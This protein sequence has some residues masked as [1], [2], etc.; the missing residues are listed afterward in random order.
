MQLSL[1]FIFLPLTCN[2]QRVS[3]ELRTARENVLRLT[4]ASAEDDRKD[5][6]A[7]PRL[8]PSLMRRLSPYPSNG[9]EIS[10]VEP[11]RNS[12][13][14][15]TAS[16]SELHS[17]A[18][19]NATTSNTLAAPSPLVHPASDAAAPLSG[20]HS[21]TV[22]AGTAPSALEAPSLLV[23]PT[24]DV[25]GSSSESRSATANAGA[26]P[27]TLA[28]PV[29][30]PQPA[31]AGG[32]YLRV[33]HSAAARRGAGAA[34]TAPTP[35]VQPTSTVAGFSSG[36]PST[37]AN[38][39]ALVSEISASEPSAAGPSL[40]SGQSGDLNPSS[41]LDPRVSTTDNNVCQA[42]KDF[43][44]KL[45]ALRQSVDSR[46]VARRAPAREAA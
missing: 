39:G 30:S 29:P 44:Q 21:A 35:P 23:Q 43:Y 42:M 40:P 18:A 31:R 7:A 13:N 6:I 2:S 25:A 14:P 8:D 3:A 1:G 19:H 5:G 46:S 26:T 20:S 32:S 24:S 36:S 27:S 28:I 38:T 37:T 16:P 34:L 11:S 15:S 22:N 33:S 41:S 9:A 45:A 10:D 4:M 12:T 17:T